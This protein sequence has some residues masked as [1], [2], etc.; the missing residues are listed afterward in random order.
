[1]PPSALAMLT[2]VQSRG[3]NR[4]VTNTFVGGEIAVA[5]NVDRRAA[6]SDTHQAARNRGQDPRRCG[7]FAF[8]DHRRIAGGVRAEVRTL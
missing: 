3:R 8:V 2:T 6:L 1:M 5:T 4:D 7:V